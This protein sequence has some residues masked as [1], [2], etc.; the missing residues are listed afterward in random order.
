MKVEDRQYIVRDKESIEEAFALMDRTDIRRLFVVDGDE[1]L[2]GFVDSVGLRK[3]ISD[4]VSSKEC[5]S[6]ILSAD[7]P[8]LFDTD[9]DDEAELQNK[10]KY[11]YHAY[12]LSDIDRIPICAN[13][14]TLLH[15]SHFNM[16][17][18][19]SNQRIV[20]D[21]MDEQNHELKR[22]CIIGGGG[23][24]GSI[25]A[26]RLLRK[27]Y[28]VRIFDTFIFGKEPLDYLKKT[29]VMESSVGLLDIYDGDMRNMSDVFMALDGVDAV[30]LLGAVVGDPASSKYPVATFEV[31]YIATQAIAEICAYLNINRVLFASTCSV[32]GQADQGVVADENT[33]LNPISHYARTKIQAESALLRVSSPNFAPTIMR[34]STLYG[35]SHRMRYD[36]VVNTMVMKALTTGKITVFGGEQWR[37][38]LCVDD[39]T[40]AFIAV[41][42]ADINVVK[43]QVYNVGDEKENYQIKELGVLITDFLKSK[44][45]KVDMEI[46]PNNLDLRDYKVSFEKLRSATGF[47]AQHSVA[48]TLD[49]LYQLIREDLHADET[50]NVSRYNDQNPIKTMATGNRT[51][52]YKETL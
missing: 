28:N 48:S 15:F 45:E 50:A 49:R 46:I 44:G 22:I 43:K 6:T 8:F 1:R 26:E 25:L 5:V 40:D 21:N 4:G 18:L 30:V 23:Y 32:Y 20:I 34:M 35:P 9:I 52:L 36:L 11:L 13:N 38:L 29:G 19:A 16:L 10:I 51:N 12:A 41:L 31:N 2:I 42:E 3:C 39:A 37:P 27:G 33:S 47:H 17:R 14:M 24:L 7:M